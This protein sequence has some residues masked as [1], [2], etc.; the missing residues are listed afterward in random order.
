VGPELMVGLNIDDH[1]EART[2]SCGP[3]SGCSVGPVLG[4]RAV[5]EAQT[6]SCLGGLGCQ[7]GLCWGV[8]PVSQLFCFSFSCM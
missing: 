2:K 3:E 6:R 8:G 4:S 7:V 5:L 1:L